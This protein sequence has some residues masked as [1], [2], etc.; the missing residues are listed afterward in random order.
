MSHRLQVLIPEELD[1][2]LRKMAQRSRMSKG[3]WVRLALEKSLE[4]SEGDRTALLRLKSLAAPTCD[5][6][7]M[8]KEIEAGRS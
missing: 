3:R 7:K 6:G 2:R 4:H 5:I 8:L 1:V